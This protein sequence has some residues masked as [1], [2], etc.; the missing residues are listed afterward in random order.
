MKHTDVIKPKKRLLALLACMV[1]A[2]TLIMLPMI[3]AYGEDEPAEYASTSINIHGSEAPKAASAELLMAAVDESVIKEAAM[4]QAAQEPETGIGTQNI[5]LWIS[6][7]LT[8]LVI[9]LAAASIKRME[10]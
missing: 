4:Q 2:T 5:I 3:S 1:I 7:G 10:K 9:V 6:L 8:A